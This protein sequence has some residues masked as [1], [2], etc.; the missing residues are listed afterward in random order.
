M[1]GTWR[2][3]GTQEKSEDL[4]AYAC[5]GKQRLTWLVR[6]AGYAFRMDVPFSII[7][8]VSMRSLFTSSSAGPDSGLAMVSL[9]LLKP[10][11]DFYLRD[12]NQIEPV[13]VQGGDSPQ[14]WK[15]CLDWTERRQATEVRKIDVIGFANHLSGFVQFLHQVVSVD[16]LQHHQ[17]RLTSY[18]SHPAHTVEQNT[19]ASSEFAYHGISSGPDSGKFVDRYLYPDLG[20]DLDTTAAISGQATAPQTLAPIMHVGH[21]HPAVGRPHD[22]EPSFAQPT[23]ISA[24]VLPQLAYPLG[25]QHFFRDENIFTA[26]SAIDGISYSPGDLHRASPPLLTTPF[27]PRLESISMQSTY[28]SKDNVHTMSREASFQQAYVP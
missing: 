13:T 28:N 10:P 25:G 21:H 17:Q 6:S 15:R 11:E 19:L 1:I 2:R 9:F 8:N 12:A 18:S 5:K 27:H 20:Y 4:V 14:G 24:P 16:V 22:S 26:S 7:Q 3:V 23:S